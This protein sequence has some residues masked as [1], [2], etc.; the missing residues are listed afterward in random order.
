MNK[1]EEIKQ[2]IIKL[3]GNTNKVP[4]FG[5]HFV[6]N[7][8]HYF[9]VPDKEHKFV[10]F[11]IPHIIK[12]NDMDIKD[13]TDII[14]ETN[15]EVKFIKAVILENSSISISYDHK[16]ADQENIGHIVYHIINTLDFAS[17]YLM[18]KIKEKNC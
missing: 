3:C 2:E 10:R 17:N 5:W 11:T 13:V 9:Y 4:A 12:V 14:N 8:L 6:Y 16:I 7:D 15:R 1:Q 18:K